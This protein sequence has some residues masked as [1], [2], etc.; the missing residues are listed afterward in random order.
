MA[1]YVYNS[2]AVVVWFIRPK[3]DCQDHPKPQ[4][5]CTKTLRC[6]HSCSG[7]QEKKCLP[8]L[9]GCK[10]PVKD[11]KDSKLHHLTQNANDNCVICDE[12]LSSAP[13]IQV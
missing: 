10:T 12:K 1:V 4:C 3:E 11:D 9:Y 5:I 2:I 7:I 13:C 8:C 6:G